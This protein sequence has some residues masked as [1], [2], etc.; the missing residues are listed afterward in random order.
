MKT[1]E[2]K[3]LK[4]EFERSEADNFKSAIS[5]I[6]RKN[7]IIECGIIGVKGASQ[8]MN[9]DEIKLIRALNERINQEQK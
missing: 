6:E 3:S 2:V 4:I 5:K 9:S 1:E 7:S 8:I